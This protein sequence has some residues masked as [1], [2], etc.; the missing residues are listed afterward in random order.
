MPPNFVIGQN[1]GCLH[2]PDYVHTPNLCRCCN[3]IDALFVDARSCQ[4]VNA[5]SVPM[6]QVCRCCECVGAESVCHYV[7]TLCV[8]RCCKCVAADSLLLQRECQYIESVDASSVSMLSVCVLMLGVFQCCKC[9]DAECVRQCCE[10]HGECADATCGC[11]MFVGW[12]Q[13]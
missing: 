7:L 4:Y 5:A 1:W 9:V 3:C 10:C 11:G 12:R 8:R 13:L 2:T 6:Q